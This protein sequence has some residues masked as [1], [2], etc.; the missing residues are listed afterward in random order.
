MGGQDREMSARRDLDLVHPKRNGTI[1]RMPTRLLVPTGG[2]E[3]FCQMKV[4]LDHIVKLGHCSKANIYY[5]YLLVYFTKTT[6]DG[7]MQKYAYFQIRT[8]KLYN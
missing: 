1:C 4:D 3:Y 6:L 8:T 7:Q 2:R 5:Y